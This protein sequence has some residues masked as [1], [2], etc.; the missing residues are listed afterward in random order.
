MTLNDLFV[1]LPRNS[2]RFPLN[3]TDRCKAPFTMTFGYK[4]KKS[5]S[6]GAIR[7]HPR[8]WQK[9]TLHCLPCGQQRT[10]DSVGP[11][12]AEASMAFEQSQ[13]NCFQIM[14]LEPTTNS[15]MD[16]MMIISSGSG[17]WRMLF[18]NHLACC[19]LRDVEWVLQN[20]RDIFLGSPWSLNWPS[21]RKEAIE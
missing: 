7:N 6:S 21:L 8:P 19:S 4:V 20:S 15:P 14:K 2:W 10:G 9:L 1:A 18:G 17:P 13:N 12:T 16:S 3:V 11:C 5:L